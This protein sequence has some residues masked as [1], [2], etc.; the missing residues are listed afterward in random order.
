MDIPLKNDTSEETPRV[1]E[2]TAEGEEAVLEIT[3]R[4]R[5]L[6]DFVG[7]EQLKQNLGI[8]IAAAKKR[9]EPLEHLLFYGNPGL[10]KT[11]LAHIISREMEAP[12]TVTSGPALEKIG[13]LAAILSNLQTG[14]VL[15]IDEIHRLNRT[16]EEVLY[17]AL[18]DFSLDI[19]L[20]KGPAARTIRMPLNRF[21]LI[22]ATTKLSLIS[23]PLRDR[24]GH[25]HHLNFYEESDIEK[26]IR[27]NASILTVD[28]DNVAIQMLATRARRTPRVANRLLKRVRDVA[29]VK[30]EGKITEPLTQ[31]AF[32]MLG[33]DTLGLDEID[34]RILRLLIE[35]FGGGPVGLNTLSAAIAEEMDTIETIYEPF[36]LQRGLIERTPR[37]RRATRVAYEHLGLE[38]LA[39]STLF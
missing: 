20:G 33:V 23:G 11:T 34:R 16:I 2:P 31:E 14:E 36:L 6:L 5:S 38:Y 19:V 28:I 8:S 7:Q 1:V 17:P 21:T 39:P 24:F 26:I 35:K 9:D 10:G 12:I 18:E 22:G 4:P 30:G 3:L 27:R 25:T 13:D 15:F 37:G 32:R 29:Q